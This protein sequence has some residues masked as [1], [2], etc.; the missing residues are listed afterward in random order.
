M[1]DN[2]NSLIAALVDDLEPVR[3]LRRSEG[4][5]LV[6]GAAV[7]TAL[8]VFGLNGLA[9][10]V[11]DGTISPMFLLANGLLLVLG[12]AACASTIAM[13]SPRVGARHDGACWAMLTAG[14]FPAAAIALLMMRYPDWPYLLD[15]AQGWHCFAEATLTSLLVAGALLFWLRRGAPVSP[16]TSGLY[17]GVGAT[18]LGSAVFGMSCPVD[19]IYHLGIWHALPVV[20]G[21]LAGRFLVP[22]LLRW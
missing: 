3:P 4:G 7:L 17:M 5:A 14:V 16:R 2:S 15:A 19:T 1:E 11:L 9:G 10:N 18:A 21:G 20:L 22:R 6:A 12:L 8:A 13:A